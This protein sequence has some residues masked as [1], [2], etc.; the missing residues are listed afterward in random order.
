MQTHT[1]NARA[2]A[3]QNLAHAAANDMADALAPLAGQEIDQNT[4][5][6][7]AA[8][9]FQSLAAHMPVLVNVRHAL[10]AIPD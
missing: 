4:R 3:L 7:I 5:D 8:D 9:V 1:D 6:K 10:D 2:N